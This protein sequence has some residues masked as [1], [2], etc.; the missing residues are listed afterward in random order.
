MS[1][2]VALVQ[3]VSAQV[4]FVTVTKHAEQP[5][6]RENAVPPKTYIILSF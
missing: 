3:G 6:Q 2:E 4:W 5:N 1:R